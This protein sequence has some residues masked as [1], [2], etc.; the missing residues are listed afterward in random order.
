MPA[1]VLASTFLPDIVSRMRNELPEY[2]VTAI[3]LGTR[4]RPPADVEQ[5]RVVLRAADALVPLRGVLDARVLGLTE[6]CRIIQQVGAG[7]DSVDRVVAKRLGIAVC[8]VPSRTGGNAESVAEMALMHLIAAGREL[9]SLQAMVAREDFAAPFGTSLYGKT[10]V[11]V[12]LGNIGRSLARLLR[13]F[14]CRVIGIRRHGAGGRDAGAEV[15]SPERLVAAVSI[16]DFVAVTIP[17]TPVTEGILGREELAAIKPSA[18]V[19]NVSRGGTIDREA[20]LEALRSGRVS[21]VGL[22]VFWEEPLPKEDEILTYE[23]IGTPHCGGLTDHM[24]AGTVAAA[25]ENIRRTVEGGRP[26]FRVRL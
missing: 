2:T 5:H 20:L 13:P 12:G 23:M 3:D 4:D 17:L 24:L 10:V 25:A 9:R 16:A 18:R 19:V 15:W 1:V 6:H 7:V 22:D 21:A 26:R 14:R 11:I 8:N